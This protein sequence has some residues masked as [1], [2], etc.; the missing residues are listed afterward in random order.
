MRK[1]LELL[2]FNIFIDLPLYQRKEIQVPSHDTQILT[3]QQGFSVQKWSQGPI[4]SIQPF[5]F[6]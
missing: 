2:W 4:L 3:Q 1:I 5:I 6:P